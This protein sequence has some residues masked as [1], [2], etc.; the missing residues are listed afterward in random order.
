[1]HNY[2]DLHSWSKEYRREVMREAKTRRL[3]EETRT[4]GGPWHLGLAWRS[5]LAPLRRGTRVA[6]W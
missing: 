1:M 2:Y 5:L 6:G 3:L 4:T